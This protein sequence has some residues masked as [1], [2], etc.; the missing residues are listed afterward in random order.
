MYWIGHICVCTTGMDQSVCVLHIRCSWRGEWVW[1]GDDVVVVPKMDFNCKTYYPNVRL[2]GGQL[3]VD[4]W[5]EI[6]CGR[7][8][9][10]V[11]GICN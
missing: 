4:S 6:S 10:G 7:S 11:G 1:C 8:Y 5:K 9:A 3:M 2:I